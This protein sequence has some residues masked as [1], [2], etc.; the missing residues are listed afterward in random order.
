MNRINHYSQR[1]SFLYEQCKIID[2]NTPTVIT[3]MLHRKAYY[4]WKKW[5]AIRDSI[6][7]GYKKVEE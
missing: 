4:E 3:W 1:A 6:R 7:R 5:S 2:N